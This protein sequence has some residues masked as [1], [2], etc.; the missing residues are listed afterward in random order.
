MLTIF[1]LELDHNT[2]RTEN[3]FLDNPHFRLGMGEDRGIDEETFISETVASVM[4][5]RT[6]F[7]AGIDVA[8]D[9]LEGTIIKSLF[10]H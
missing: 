6:L 1:V 5:R 10:I 4:D 3:L 9:A 7:L 8:H 2:D